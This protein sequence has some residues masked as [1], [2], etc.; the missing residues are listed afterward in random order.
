M[1]AKLQ[2]NCFKIVV[3]CKWFAN[4]P[5]N[6]RIGFSSILFFICLMPIHAIVFV[7]NKSTWCKM[8][9]IVLLVNNKGSSALN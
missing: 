6:Y 4:N 9:F 3:W 5:I 2:K 8:I 1:I 7:S